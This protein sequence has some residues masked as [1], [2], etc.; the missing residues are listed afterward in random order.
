MGLS[1]IAAGIESTTKQQTRQVATIDDTDITLN[2]C[3][4]Q[5]ESELPCTAVAAATVLEAYAT[6]T[7]IETAARSAGIAPVTAAKTLHRCGKPGIMPLAP[8]GQQVLRDWLAG[9]LS[10]VDALALTQTDEPTFALAA[11]VETHEIIEPIADVLRRDV[12]SC[13]RHNSPVS[14]YETSS[15]TRD[16]GAHL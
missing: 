14:S 7:G 15:E 13:P 8:T 3:L 2:E 5:H 11:Y 4:D 6:G 10:R 9:Q 12:A 16:N 1:D